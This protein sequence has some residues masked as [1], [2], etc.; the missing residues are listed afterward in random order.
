M[1]NKDAYVREV[2]QVKCRPLLLFWDFSLRG[3]D[4]WVL[5][6]AFDYC[7]FDLPLEEVPEHRVRSFT[8]L[9]SICLGE[10]WLYERF[11]TYLASPARVVWLS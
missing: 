2:G 5:F 9:Y 8:A 4:F 3:E 10:T 7:F 6:G 11:F 1:G